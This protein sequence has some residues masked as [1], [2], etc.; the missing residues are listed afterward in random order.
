MCFEVKKQTKGKLSQLLDKMT[1]EGVWTRRLSQL[2]SMQPG[3]PSCGCSSCGDSWWPR[4][5][6]RP[7]SSAEGPRWGRGRGTSPGWPPLPPAAG[8]IGGANPGRPGSSRLSPGSTGLRGR[9]GG[10][11]G[12]KC[13]VSFFVLFYHTSKSN[14]YMN[15]RHVIVYDHEESCFPSAH[16]ISYLLEDGKPP[17]PP[18]GW[19][20][21]RDKH[22]P[23]RGRWGRPE[24]ETPGAGG[25]G[26][27][28]NLCKRKTFN[29]WK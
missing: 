1:P 9:G 13:L 26:T 12:G 23:R 16:K 11:G 25:T 15:N 2:L 7:P 19:S 29:D 10:G 5:R 18:L 27:S 17:Q 3:T 21:G 6:E 14:Y 8:R 20:C 24:P 28:T 22:R 4:G